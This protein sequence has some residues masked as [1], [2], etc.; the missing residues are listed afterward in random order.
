MLN[1][2]PAFTYPGFTYVDAFGVV[3]PTPACC[4]VG[5]TYYGNDANN[6]YNAF[7]I[8][9]EK[10]VSKGLQFIAHYTF[11]HAFAYDTNHY[12]TSY[13]KFA[14]G[15]NPDNRNQ[16]FVINTIY[17]L[18]FGRGRKYM[19]NVG[20]AADLLIGG[21]QITNTTTYGTGLPWTPSIAECSQVT[22]VD[23]CR[24]N[25]A[26]GKLHT[27]VTHANGNTYWFTPVAPLAYPPLSG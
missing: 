8:K 10:R 1:G 13:K 24:P 25:V 16:V 26:S 3:T 6:N 17:E 15:P 23:I 2:V 18:P 14:W 9:A 21:W 4:A 27:G 22:D 19:S 11:S 7:Q 5:T 20:R 12:S